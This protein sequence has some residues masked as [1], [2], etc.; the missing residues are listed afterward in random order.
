DFLF[1][2]WKQHNGILQRFVEPKG[3]RNALV[4]AV[5]SP[6]V[7]LLERRVNTRQ[8]HDSRFGLS[9]R[10]VTFDGPDAFSR[11]CPLRG[12][13][14]PSEIQR[15]CEAV[16]AHVAEVSYQKQQIRSMVLSFKVGSPP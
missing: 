8:L 6:K 7:C 2:R 3:T 15:V 11:S 12:S 13:V 4:H 10:A 14:L 16:A 9:E 1:N 5:W